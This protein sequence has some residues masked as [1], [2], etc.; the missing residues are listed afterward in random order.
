MNVSLHQLD[1]G[2]EAHTLAMRQ[3]ACGHGDA[4]TA[5]SI[6]LHQA[7]AQC[8]THEAAAAQDE[9]ALDVARHGSSLLG[10]GAAASRGP[11]GPP[12]RVLS[13]GAVL[14]STCA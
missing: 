8:A 5:S 7:F 4:A 3:A 10:T 11:M 9:D 13:E 14:P 12:R 1:G 6:A 2:Q